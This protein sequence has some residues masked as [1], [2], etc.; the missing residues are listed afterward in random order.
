M[1]GLIWSTKSLMQS[2]LS[3]CW[4]LHRYR[5]ACTIFCSVIAIKKLIRF[6]FDP[7]RLSLLSRHNTPST[8]CGFFSTF[9]L[10]SRLYQEGTRHSTLETVTPAMFVGVHSSIIYMFLTDGFFDA[11]QMPVW[12]MIFQIYISLPSFIRW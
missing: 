3:K 7:T 4:R 10:N 1:S 11:I 2:W 6:C 5:R 9:T 8:C 12:F